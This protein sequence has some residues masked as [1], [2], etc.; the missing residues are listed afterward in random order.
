MFVIML[1]RINIGALVRFQT[2]RENEPDG[3]IFVIMGINCAYIQ[4]FQKHLMFKN[5]E[6]NF[7]STKRPAL[8][9]SET[10]VRESQTK[11]NTIYFP[12]YYHLSHSNPGFGPD[13]NWAMIRLSRLDRPL[14]RL[15]R[16]KLPLIRPSRPKW[17]L[18]RL[19]RP[20]CPL[21]RPNPDHGPDYCALERLSRPC[22]FGQGTQ[23]CAFDG[24]IIVQ[25][26]SGPKP[27]NLGP[28]NRRISPTIASPP[29]LSGK[30][31]PPSSI[32]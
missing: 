3:L 5:S 28:F 10:R 29:L 9:C 6:L 2:T 7:G 17:S 1:P 14:I 4:Q 8:K 19:S 26:G 21:I 30:N 12:N 22:N 32:S 18:I 20:K 25:F 16:P 24:L 11:Q 13:P 23:G 15:S 31:P 27:G